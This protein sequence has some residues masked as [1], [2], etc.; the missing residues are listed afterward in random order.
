MPEPLAEVEFLARSV[1][2]IEI[3]ATLSADAYTRRELGEAVDASQPTIGRVLNDLSARSWIDY[4]GERYEATATGAY[5]AAGITDLRDRLA[6]ETRLR[7]VIDYFPFDAVDVG[8]DALADAR[9]TTPSA[10]RPNAPIERMTELLR[11]TS[12]TSLVSYAFNRD[13]LAFL[14]DRA[15]DGD[16][17]ARGVFTTEAIDPIAADPTLRGMLRD[18]L[19]APGVEMRV[20]DEFVP[21]AVEVTDERT[22]FLLRDADGVVRAALD[23]ENERVRA[24]AEETLDRYW[25]AAEPL[26]SDRLTG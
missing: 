7:E 14:R 23:T 24:W 20:T 19:D 21:F 6:T 25:T 17:T 13:K 4:D 12:H 1:N 8:L 15:V 9:I 5:V 26:T 18:V 2:R 11:E 3:L 22:H 16:L 10:P